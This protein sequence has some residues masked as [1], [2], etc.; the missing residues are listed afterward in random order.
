MFYSL[1]FVVMKKKYYIIVWVSIFIVFVLYISLWNGSKNIKN[2]NNNTLIK[3]TLIKKEKIIYENYAI[4]DLNGH[5]YPIK[6]NKELKKACFDTNTWYK[7]LSNNI[8]EKEIKMPNKIFDC[9]SKNLKWEKISTVKRWDI[10][11]DNKW[12]IHKINSNVNINIIWYK[13]YWQ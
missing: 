9:L 6:I 12:L 1:M 4:K 5:S 8:I 3:N 13:I 10:I 2:V 11:I 7:L